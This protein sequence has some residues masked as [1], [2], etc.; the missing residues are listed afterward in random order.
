LHRAA[1]YTALLQRGL[2]L[3]LLRDS[4]GRRTLPQNTAPEVRRC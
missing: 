1:L 3:L 2:L 4:I